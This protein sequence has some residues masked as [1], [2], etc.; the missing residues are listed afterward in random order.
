MA[1]VGCHN[2]FGGLIFFFIMRSTTGYQVG[3]VGLVE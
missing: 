1:V 2:F 3:F